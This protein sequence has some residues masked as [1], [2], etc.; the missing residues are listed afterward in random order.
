MD[1][2]ELQ[3]KIAAAFPG[4]RVEVKD[5]T[6]GGDHFDAL[7]VSEKFEGRSLVERHQM[8]YRAVGDAM[9]QAVHALALKTLTPSQYDNLPR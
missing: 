1:V 2:N 5:F 4:A 8:V 6:G 9:R 3:A 7:V